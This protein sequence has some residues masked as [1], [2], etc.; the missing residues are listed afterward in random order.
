MRSTRA[1]RMESLRYPEDTKD[2]DSVLVVGSSGSKEE[3][4]GRC[5]ASNSIKAY[6]SFSRV[7]QSL[8]DGHGRKRVTR[9]HN[10]KSHLASREDRQTPRV[11]PMKLLVSHEMRC[12]L[13]LIPFFPCRSFE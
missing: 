3:N 12:V 7:T 1:T 6:F 5:A 11:T 4:N 13:L 2:R 9:A 8:E 10:N